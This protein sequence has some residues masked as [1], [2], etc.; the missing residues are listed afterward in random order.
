[1]K[2]ILLDIETAPSIAY[3]WNFW[4]QTI[5][6]DSVIDYQGYIMSCSFKDLNSNEIFYL[7]NRTEND[8]KIVSD[9]L[10]VLNSAD[11]VVAHNGKKFD[12]PFIKARAVI[13]GLNPPSPFKIVDTLKIAKEEMNFKRNSLEYLGEALGVATKSKHNKFP[14]IQLWKECMA[15]ND[16]AWEEMKDYNIRDVEVLEQIYLKLKPW[17]GSHPN[18]VVDEENT[19]MRCPK[20]GG[21]HINKRGYYYTNKGKYQRYVCLSC[22][23]W[24]SET[25][26]V[27]TLADRKNLLKGR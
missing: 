27:N 9:L 16:E 12:I 8:K 10:K 22:G 23:A 14:G 3:V 1:M 7:E 11:I 20:C 21:Y 19:T 4:K 15:G 24:S 26:T 17:Y 5:Q 6:H 2:T 25:Y 13:H 18:V